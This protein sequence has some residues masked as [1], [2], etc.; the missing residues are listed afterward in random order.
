MMERLSHVLWIGGSPCAG[1]STLGH[2]IARTH[3]F[4]DYHLDPMGR[5]HMRR[6]LAAGDANLEAF[7][8]M[9]MDQRWLER[10]VEELVQEVL[11]S[12]TK[13]C[14]LAVED[15]LAMP[16]EWFIVAEG[17]FF[18]ECVAPYLSSPHQ[19]IWLVPTA[20]FCDQIRR[21]RDAEQARRRER[22]GVADESSDPERRLRNL[23]ERDCQLAHYVKEQAEKL[24]L[25]VYEVDGSRSLDEM[26][27]LVEK[28]FEPYLVEYLK[29]MRE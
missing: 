3:V 2:T 13:E 4:L 23:I 6:R 10:S 28:H 26:T 25:T 17:N 7:L 1:K 5:N 27:M 8:K 12:W 14:Q 20:S 22:H 29:Q 15:L 24:H 21:T 16:D 11:E 18:P 9:S 19:A